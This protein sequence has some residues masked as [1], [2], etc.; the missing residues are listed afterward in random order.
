[1]GRRRLATKLSAALTVSFLV[2]VPNSLAASA[3]S[4]SFR[5]IIVF[6]LP[7]LLP[8]TYRRQYQ[9]RL[10]ETSQ[11]PDRIGAR[12]ALPLTGLPGWRPCRSSPPASTQPRHAPPGILSRRQGESRCARATNHPPPAPPRHDRWRT[13]PRRS[14]PK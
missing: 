13:P 1:M 2:V 3:K 14:P 12:R 7:S 5:S 10:H 6:M 9:W 11:P 4:S 8:R